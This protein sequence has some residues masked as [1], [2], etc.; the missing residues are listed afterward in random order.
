[1]K[2]YFA[3]L[4]FAVL[5]LTACA[6]QREAEDRTQRLQSRYA[7]AEGCDARV[8]VSSVCGGETLCYTLD[9]RCENG[10]THVTVLSPEELAGVGA[11][12]RDGEKLTLAFDGAMLDAGSAGSGVSALN[13][14]DILLRAAAEG[15]VTE[16]SEERFDGTDA[17]RLC[18][19][20]E[21]DGQ[22]LFVTG[23]FDDADRPLYAEIEQ[24]GEILA[25]LQFTDFTFR[26][27]L[28]A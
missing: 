22:K 19:E 2:R 26:D 4:V 8:E 11:T 6:A 7:A 20:T 17:L 15:Y 14:S 1:M 23:Y 9:V 24:N 5:T 16:W 10:E 13:A 28:T 25:Y 18:F 3:L 21:R 27:I 12:V